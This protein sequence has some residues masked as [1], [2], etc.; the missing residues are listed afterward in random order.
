MKT[1]LE[2]VHEFD[3]QIE[4]LCQ[5]HEDFELFASLPGAGRVYASRLLTVMGV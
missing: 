3:V 4:E 5:A 1:T 2:A